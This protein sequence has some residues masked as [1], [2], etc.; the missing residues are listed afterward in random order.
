MNSRRS[1]I[2]RTGLFLA[3]LPAAAAALVHKPRVEVFEAVPTR[4]SQC[5]QPF[6]ARAC[7]PTH[8]L[9]HHEHQTLTLDELNCLLEKNKPIPRPI[10]PVD[11]QYVFL[12]QR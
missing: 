1:F 11:G 10:Q 6:S 12:V 4:C 9:I 8:A 5:G 3:G 7:G 2:T